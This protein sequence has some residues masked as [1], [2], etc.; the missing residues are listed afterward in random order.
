MSILAVL[1][2]YI[3]KDRD[4]NNKYFSNLMDSLFI[5][6][7]PPAYTL[8]IVA[9]PQ[10]AAFLNHLLFSH[11]LMFICLSVCLSLSLYIYYRSFKHPLTH[12]L[13]SSVKL[14]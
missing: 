4:S 1:Y 2:I 3:F 5:E 9:G 12:I 7:P 8:C 10:N 6:G 14:Q 13:L 11:V